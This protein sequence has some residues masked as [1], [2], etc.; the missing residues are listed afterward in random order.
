[1]TGLTGAAIANITNRLL[2]ERLILQ[3]GRLRG[4]R[5]QPATEL[6]ITPTAV[7]R[8]DSMSTATTSRWS[9]SIS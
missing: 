5:G 8:L 9:S 4:A 2:G 3:A 1:M 7:S 6:V